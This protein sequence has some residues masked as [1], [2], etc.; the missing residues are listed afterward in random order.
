MPVLLAACVLAVLAGPPASALAARPGAARPAPAAA[1]AA[2]RGA[3]AEDGATRVTNLTFTPRAPSLR[4]TGVQFVDVALTLADPDGVRPREGVIVDHG[5][6]CPCV[7]VVNTR[8][9]EPRSRSVIPVALHLAEGTQTEGVWIGRFAVGAQNAGFWQV[10]GIDAGDLTKI[11]AFSTLVGM[12]APWNAV[13]L[14]V[15]G[16]DWPSIWMG[17]RVRLRPGV[18]VVRGGMSLTRSGRPVANARLE[19][20]ENCFAFMYPTYLAAVRTDAKGRYSFTLPSTREI[21][22]GACAAL[23]AY[24]TDTPGAMVAQS[25]VRSLPRLR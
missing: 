20:R 12:P 18:D 21:D 23:V 14:N 25:N 6:A 9:V 22:N 2:P 13:I 3:A 8:A 1:D 15:R 11:D 19:I 17:T 24:P 5:F 7:T 4:G 16:Y 10:G